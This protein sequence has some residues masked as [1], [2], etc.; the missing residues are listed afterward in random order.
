MAK[1]GKHVETYTAS[2]ASTTVIDPSEGFM[3]DV[4]GVISLCA[5]GDQA[6]DAGDSDFF[7]D[8]P[9]LKGVIYPIDAAKYDITG[10]TTLTQ[11]WVI[12][13]QNQ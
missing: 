8:I 6:A 9:V 12:F 4:D 10:S 13:G 11:I 5:R 3:V 7:A 1:I 2:L